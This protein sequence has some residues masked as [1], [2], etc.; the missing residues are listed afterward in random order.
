MKNVILYVRVSTDEQAGRGYSLRDQEQKLL[1]YC[2]NNNLNVLHIFRED[3]SA[4]TFKRPEFK[5]LLEYCKKN[6][7][8]V[9]QMI[10]IKWDRFSRNTAESY[11]MISV[12]NQLAIQV[13]AIEQPLDLTVPEQGLMLAVY[14]SIPEVENQ[15]RSLNVIS[16]MRRAF[17]EGRYVGNAPKGYSNGIDANKK[18]LLVPNEDAKYIQEG[19]ELMATGLYNQKEVFNKLKSKGFKSSMTAI[20]SIFRNHLYYGGVFIKG[21]KEEE[22]MVVEGIHEPLI[23][24]VLFQKVQDVINNRTKKYHTAHKKINEK[25]PLKGFLNC[26][27]CN[28]PLTASTSKGRSKH[29][30]YYHCISP[31][32]ERYRIEDVDLWFSDFLKSITL[33]KPVQ[34]LFIEMIKETLA[35]Q[36]G[37]SELG[38]KHYEQVKNIE[39]KIIRLQ[40]LYIEGNI[41][42]SEYK[43]AK[44]RYTKIHEELKS[45]EVDLK[46]KK[47]VFENFEKA[48][49]KLET[50]ENQY[51]ESYIEGKRKIIGSIFPKKFQFE[52]NKVRT[53]D[54]NP[55]FLKI[56][57][58]NSASQGIKKRTNSKKLSLSRMVGD[59]GFEPPTP[60]V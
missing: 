23:T 20:A 29:Y 27:S 21:Y 25:F 10:F 58:I 48:I 28:T 11:Q 14:L 9:H 59:E 18:P 41:E 15:R 37:K 55:L 50:I 5:K 30:T 49:L 44:E 53:A 56:A 32:N 34:K 22:E 35:K 60:S 51:H 8:E 13:N 45:K 19:F 3:F 46:D 43:I 54:I 24:K 12:F 6:K 33:E 2:Q 26:P 16:G 1:T 36:H 42:K 4:K 31:C 39:E 7:K 40:D 52:N 38:P 57:S 47:I 17:K